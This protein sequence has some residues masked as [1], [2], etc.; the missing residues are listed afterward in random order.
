VRVEADVG[1]DGLL[2]VG[3]EEPR[4]RL[5]VIGS[6]DRACVGRAAPVEAEADAE[7]ELAFPLEKD[8]GADACWCR[9]ARLVDRPA[10]VGER[11]VILDAN[12][13]K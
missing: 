4:R 5:A 11:E 10:P 7:I 1:G 13:E 8:A 2:V 9:V 6:N 12:A 3:L